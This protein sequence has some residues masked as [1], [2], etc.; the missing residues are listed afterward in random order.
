MFFHIS[1]QK[2]N[3][4]TRTTDKTALEEKKEDKNNNYS[5]ETTTMITAIKQHLQQQQ[6]NVNDSHS[7]NKVC[8]WI[9]ASC[10]LLKVTSGQTS[11]KTTTSAATTA[12]EAINPL[13][14]TKDFAVHRIFLR[15]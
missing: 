14:C 15:V 3:K 5:N 10:Q 13:K 2:A 11:N 8:S 12:T 9:L 4:Q 1:K 6:N 7:N